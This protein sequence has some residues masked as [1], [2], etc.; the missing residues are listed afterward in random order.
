MKSVM[1]YWKEGSQTLAEG[2]SATSQEL[3]AESD[4]LNDLVQQF[5]LK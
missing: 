2:S 3:S 4:S 5:K 1:R